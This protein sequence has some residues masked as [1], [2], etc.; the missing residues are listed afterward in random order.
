MNEIEPIY[1]NEF[2]FGFYWKKRPAEQKGKIQI[3][4]RDTG[5]YLDKAEVQ[6][7]LYCVD[8]A[9]NAPSCNS[10]NS[11][12]CCRSI[13]LRTPSQKIDLAVNS[14]ELSGIEDLLGGILFHLS[15]R[16]YLRDI[17]SN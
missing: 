7:F 16:T 13:L 4:F 8:I 3:I 17:S 2:G 11:E 14:A 5:F 6:D 12:T 9:K 15:L 1:K 10:C